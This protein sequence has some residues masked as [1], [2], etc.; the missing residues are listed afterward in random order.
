[1]SR[2]PIRRLR[3]LLMLMLWLSAVV[4][5][6][7]S[8]ALT[9]RPA[10]AGPTCAACCACHLGCCFFDPVAAGVATAISGVMAAFWAWLYEV[11]FPAMKAMFSGWMESHR[12][13]MTGDSSIRD[14]Y[15]VH[16]Y[17]LARQEEASRL[18]VAFAPTLHSQDC[19][20]KTLRRAEASTDACGRATVAGVTNAA[21]SYLTGAPGSPT[22]YGAIEALR[23]RYN[24]FAGRGL[25]ELHRNYPGAPGGPAQ[26]G[27]MDPYT[28]LFKP[29]Q[30]QTRLEQEAASGAMLNLL[31]TPLFE[32]PRGGLA[33]TAQGGQDFLYKRTIAARTLMMGQG[34]IDTYVSRL[35]PQTAD[36]QTPLQQKGKEILKQSGRMPNPPEHLSNRA[37]E[38]ALRESRM[39]DPFWYA[40]MIMD[41]PEQA[42][43]ETMRTRIERIVQL[44]QINRRL[45]TDV[46]GVG[47]DLVL[48]AVATQ[49]EAPIAA[50]VPD[51]GK[52][53]GNKDLAAMCSGGL[54]NAN[55]NA[56]SRCEDLLT[57]ALLNG[58][59]IQDTLNMMSALATADP[60]WWTYNVNI[61]TYHL[62]P[63]DLAA[64]PGADPIQATYTI[65]RPDGMRIEI[66]SWYGPG[67]IGKTMAGGLIFQDRQMTGADG[68]LYWPVASNTYP[69]GT[70]LIVC[71]TS[72]TM[73]VVADTG[74]F[75]KY[76]RTIDMSETGLSSIG[77]TTDNKGA[78]EPVTSKPIGCD[79][80]TFVP[81]HHKGH[82]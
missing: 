54:P 4:L 6:P 68:N 34:I 53:L 59:N 25:L 21:I 69:L 71:A 39:M 32:M 56:M 5:P 78:K 40:N 47:Q 33:L 42:W 48:K 58:L 66:P 74:G 50:T 73:A 26:A 65:T 17:E 61:G 45:E 52:P 15:N 75:G 16:Q 22:Y 12:I 35:S 55:A 77:G 27:D 70:L 79:S 82:C 44:A 28:A 24:A 14:G 57:Q 13:A 80:D 18:A 63:E 20:T 46:I 9:P 2:F 1:M 38:T 23:Q 3:P 51:S 37:I 30:F 8:I 7:A 43:R 62:T 36:C 10:Q 41:T 29:L 60:N 19:V 81:N 49:S 67:F 11:F 31:F 64:H 76:G 72:C